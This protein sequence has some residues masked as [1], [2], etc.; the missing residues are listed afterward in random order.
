M[1]VATSSIEVG[2]RD[3]KN[4]LSYYLR[5]VGDGEEIVVTDRGRPIARLIGM[6]GSTNR[7]EDL[8]EARLARRPVTSDRSVPKRLETA[9]PVSDLVDEQRR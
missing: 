6:D 5:R 8:I 9:G 7:L 4:Q 2:V 3:L 1:D